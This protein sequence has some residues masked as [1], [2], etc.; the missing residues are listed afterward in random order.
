MTDKKNIPFRCIVCGK[1]ALKLYHEF[2]NKK[3]IKIEH[4]SECDEVVDKYIE[5]DP[6][7]IYLD[8]MLLKIPAY[9]HILI[10]Q[11]QPVLSIIKLTIGLLFCD[12]FTKLMLQESEFS[13]EKLK[14]DR[15]FYAA[16]ELNLYWNYFLAM[17]QWFIHISVVIFLMRFSERKKESNSSRKTLLIRSIIISNCGKILVIPAILWGQTY[18]I[19]Y[20]RLSQL[21]VLLSNIQAL[22]VA[23]NLEFGLI[24]L[25]FIVGLG[26][27]CHNMVLLVLPESIN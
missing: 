9:R 27:L 10:N 3:I 20:L 14:P 2:D 16:F 25:L 12:A 4:C 15:V 6:V 21:F 13:N 17:I 7:I 22:R 26:T 11:K 24:Q 19:I 1:P 23:T 5:Y 18:G 8:A